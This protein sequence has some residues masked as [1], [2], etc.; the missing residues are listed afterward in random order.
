MRLEYQDR[1]TGQY[2]YLDNP[3]VNNIKHAFEGMNVKFCR[4]VSLRAQGFQLLIDIDMSGRRFLVRYKDITNYTDTLCLVDKAALGYRDDEAIRSIEF[5]AP[6][7]EGFNAN[8][9][10]T[11]DQQS[12]FD[13]LLHI[14]HY[15]NLP[16]NT[17]WEAY[18]Y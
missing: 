12:A 4:R 15:S 13:A 8:I 14:V 9:Y 11:V 2:R 1:N 5:I 7:G 17:E 16:K 18:Y 10:E 3:S 6:N